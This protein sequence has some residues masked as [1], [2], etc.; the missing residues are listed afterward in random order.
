MLYCHIPHYT[1][2]SS[3][4]C[5][6]EKQKNN[7]RYCYNKLDDNKFI[8]KILYII[9]FNCDLYFNVVVEKL[10]NFDFFPAL[11]GSCVDYATVANNNYYRRIYEMGIR[12]RFCL[13]ESHTWM[14]L[15]V[16]LKWV[17]EIRMAEGS[18]LDNMNRMGRR[19]CV[20]W[21]A[22]LKKKWTWRGV[23]VFLNFSILTW[24]FF[25][26]KNWKIF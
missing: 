21:N 1:C 6:H 8:R 9:N 4:S 20:F 18:I 23:E 24:N 11:L 25:K 12:T 19:W 3:R 15:L 5:T 14:V 16:F 7:R 17:R 26:Y 2:I 22:D 13:V 10:I